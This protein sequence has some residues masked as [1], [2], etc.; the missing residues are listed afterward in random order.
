MVRAT[1][2]FDGLGGGPAHVK[3]A[4]FSD[5]E[6]DPRPLSETLEYDSASAHWRFPS[7]AANW[8]DDG[9]R[10]GRQTVSVPRENVYSVTYEEK[11]P[12]LDSAEVVE[13]DAALAYEALP[14]EYSHISRA[15]HEFL[16][17]PRFD[18][19]TGHWKVAFSPTNEFE[20]DQRLRF[21]KL[22][23]RESVRYVRGADESESS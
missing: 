17:V 13:S 22:I 1:L 12:T 16:H 3:R 11:T 4:Q 7:T 19:E 8:E 6:R 21:E 18:A 2:V 5:A 15:D 14:G 9:S 20:G 10:S 23:P